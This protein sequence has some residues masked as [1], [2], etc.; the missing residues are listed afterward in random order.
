MTRYAVVDTETTGFDPR[1]SALL[2][3]AAVREDG[4]F[5][6][7]LVNPGDRKI[8]F[9]AMATH[10]ITP[11]MVADAPSAMEALA[12]IGLGHPSTMCLECNGDGSISDLRCD[13]CDGLGF[14]QT[15]PDFVSPGL[16]VFHNAEFDLGFLPEYLRELPYICTWRCSL[17]LFP[18][19][20]SHS[21]GAL[22][23]ELGLSRPMPPEAGHMPHRAL[24]DALMTRD[25]LEHMVDLLQTDGTIVG[26]EDDAD[27]TPA[28]ALRYLSWLSQQP[29]LLTK[30]RFGKHRDTHWED[31]PSAYMEWVLG[32]DFDEDT[33]HTCRHWLRERGRMRPSVAPSGE[34]RQ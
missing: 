7:S 12:D 10:H 28:S 24:F 9:G 18:H 11:E 29:V 22:W 31:I 3:V 6:Q 13:I 34:D 5:A 25:I 19:A 8:S 16:L 32:Q 17:H 15:N 20:E 27:R 33:K 21:N 30:C 23:Y 14:V 1:E 2:E 4:S 26:Y